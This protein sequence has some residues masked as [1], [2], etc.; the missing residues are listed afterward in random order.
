MKGQGLT[1]GMSNA[2]RLRTLRQAAVANG[3]CYTCRCRPKT[4]TS[5]YCAECIAKG[6]AYEK[7]RADRYQAEGRCRCGRPPLQGRAQCARCQA[8]SERVNG[9][10]KQRLIAAKLC[11]RCG[12]VKAAPDRLQCSGC[13]KRS[14]QD[15][16]DRQRELIARGICRIA[17]CGRRLKAG[18]T[19]CRS[20]LKEMREHGTPRPAHRRSK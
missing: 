2:D 6:D 10:R 17:G 20:C 18:H 19:M 7:A 14:A 5:R 16:R 15:N 3:L 11:V 9:A 13:C 1:A 8:N 4:E 12:D